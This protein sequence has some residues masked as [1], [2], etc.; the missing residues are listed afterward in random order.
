MRCRVIES[1]PVFV[2]RVES[3]PGRQIN[4]HGSIGTK[5]EI[6]DSKRDQPEGRLNSEGTLAM[7][8]VSFILHDVIIPGAGVLKVK[9][10][11]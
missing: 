11:R 1:G 3:R 5:G 8:S 6:F 10:C 2:E 7:E 9:K 4:D